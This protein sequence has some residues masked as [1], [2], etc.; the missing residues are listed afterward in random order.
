MFIEHAP[1]GSWRIQWFTRQSK[2]VA[3]VPPIME[4]QSKSVLMDFTGHATGH[5]VHAC[6]D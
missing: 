1:P 2:G 5:T 3:W 6:L 4:K